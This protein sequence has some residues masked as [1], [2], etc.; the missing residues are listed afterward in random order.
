[1]TTSTYSNPPRGMSFLYS[2][3]RLNV[4]SS[5]ARALN[6]LVASPALFEPECR[7]PQ[8]MLMAN[9][10]CRYLERAGSL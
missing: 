5:R 3:N 1:M 6:I 2:V 8:Q 10:F 9:A 7:T 4:A